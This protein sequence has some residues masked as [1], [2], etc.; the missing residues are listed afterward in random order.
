VAGGIVL[1]LLGAL[2][3]AVLAGGDSDAAPTTTTSP[4]TAAAGE[5]DEAAP[6]TTTTV[7]QT[8]ATVT[9][10]GDALPPFEQGGDPAVGIAAPAI[11]GTSFDGTPVKIAPSNGAQL[12]MFVAHWCPHC[13]REVPMVAEWIAAGE[14]P[15][16]VIMV[17]TG[18]R[19]DA[20]GQGPTLEPA[21]WLAGERWTAP[22]IADTADS[23]AAAAY[24]LTGFPYFVLI[25]DSGTVAG[26][27]AGEISIA[28]LEAF[29]AQA[30][31]T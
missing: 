1:L 26:R 14:A 13:Q 17:S 7:V 19:A 8:A 12:V 20:V 30:Q 28:D 5:S 4:T 9:V 2:A 6:T 15:L 29:V 21:D 24:G 10:T 23:Q 18:Y 3:F 25:G 11:S 16:P 22:V 31:P 27:S